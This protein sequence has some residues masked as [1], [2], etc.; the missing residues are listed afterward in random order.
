MPSAEGA[1]KLIEML[2]E[3]EE[4]KLG[5]LEASSGLSGPGLEAAIAL[6]EAL[7]YVEVENDTVRWLGPSIRGRVI[8][9]RGKIDYVLQSPLEVRVF[10]L[11]ELKAAA[12]SS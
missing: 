8:V 11:T 9:V 5:D 4:I 7:G 12:R 2:S 6:L 1:R 3:R 10:G